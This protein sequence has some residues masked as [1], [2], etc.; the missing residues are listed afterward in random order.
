M[1]SIAKWTHMFNIIFLMSVCHLNLLVDY[2]ALKTSWNWR[3][4][5]IERRGLVHFG[6]QS[7]NNFGVIS[8][9][10][11]VYWI[12]GI[13][14]SMVTGVTLGD[15]QLSYRIIVWYIYILY[16]RIYIYAE[17]IN[18]TVYV[19]IIFTWCAP[20]ILGW[21]ETC[22]W[23]PHPSPQDF[24]DLSSFVAPKSKSQVCGWCERKGASWDKLGV[25]K[26]PLDNRELR[27]YPQISKHRWVA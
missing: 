25:Y 2:G 20:F 13:S 21:L 17:K 11:M 27:S 5:S 15:R 24:A 10:S 6:L 14:L 22:P 16:V 8:M 23:S 19:H 3:N 7:P 18:H 4:N 9:A 26:V 12:V 1:I